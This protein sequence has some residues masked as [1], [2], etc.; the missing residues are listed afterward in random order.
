MLHELCFD[1]VDGQALQAFNK[2]RF[3][4]DTGISRRG[5]QKSMTRLYEANL[6][7]LM[8]GKVQL[9]MSPDLVKMNVTG[10]EQS[11]QLGVN[12]VR[13]GC[14]QSSQKLGTE[15]TP[16]KEEVKREEISDTA[17]AANLKFF[18]IK[19]PAKHGA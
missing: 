1:H 8:G 15:F 2:S 17:H 10:C 19:V 7:A 14:E 3:E 11:S 13:R 6:I 4:R 16:F 18:R 12:R 9:C 5:A